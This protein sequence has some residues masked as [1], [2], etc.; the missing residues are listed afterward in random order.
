MEVQLGGLGY[1]YYPRKTGALWFGCAEQIQ[2]SQ[3]DEDDIEATELGLRTMYE[4]GDSQEEIQ[5]LG[6]D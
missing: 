1:Q 4:S 5:V 6:L 2:K 3:S